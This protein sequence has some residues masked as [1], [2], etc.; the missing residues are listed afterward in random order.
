[1]GGGKE[2]KILIKN[3]AMKE[4]ELELHKAKDTDY[5]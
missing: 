4:V 5:G 3:H 1:M 2:G